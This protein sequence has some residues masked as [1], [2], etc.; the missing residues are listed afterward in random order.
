MLQQVQ[1]WC[2]FT[3]SYIINCWCCSSSALLCEEIFC[4]PKYQV[5]NPNRKE[6]C[7]VLKNICSK[8]PLRSKRKWGVVNPGWER[9]RERERDGEGERDREREGALEYIIW[10]E[11][12]GG[13]SVLW[14]RTE[15]ECRVLY[16]W[17]GADGVF[18]GIEQSWSVEV[19]IL[20]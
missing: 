17:V 20:G 16:S 13:W 8:T 11:K 15:L 14:A 5:S 2:N 7:D 3:E 6:L 18:Y 10:G 4:P 1:L 9:E 12:W 19:S